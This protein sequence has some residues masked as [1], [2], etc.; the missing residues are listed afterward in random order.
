MWYYE[1]NHKP[2]GPVN[3]ETIADLLRAGTINALTLVWQ[4]GMPDWKHLAETRLNDLTR[5]ISKEM[6]AVIPGTPPQIIQTVVNTASSTT[7][8]VQPARLKRLFTWWAVLMALTL[9][10]EV[11]SSFLPNNNTAVVALTCFIDIIIFAYAI[12]QFVLLYQ[13]WQI[14]QDGFSSTTPG[15]AVGFMFLPFFNLYWIFRAYCG[16]ANDQNRYITRHFDNQPGIKVR[17]AH[18]ILALLFVL[19]SFAGGILMYIFLLSNMPSTG[20]SSFD[21]T[22]MSAI[23][24]TLNV[25]SLIFSL[26]TSA[27][28]FIMFFDFYQTA[29]DIVET[30]ANQQ[31]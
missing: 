15:R 18:P 31:K 19:V 24:A 3:E 21:P 25:P 20:I 30:E 16:L 9:I 11:F 27:L 14:N 10:Y 5:S 8:R 7:P 13:F 1:L 12:L 29:L 6:P 2:V 4:E 28:A 23:L 22:T 26:L 17:R